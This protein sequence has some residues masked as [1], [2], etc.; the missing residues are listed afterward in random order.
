M[1]KIDG[2]KTLFNELISGLNLIESS[3]GAQI[4]MTGCATCLLLAA[5]CCIISA[6]LGQGEVE[7]ISLLNRDANLLNR[8][9]PFSCRRLR[10]VERFQY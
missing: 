6:Q 10:T 7:M 2:A 3:A 5:L 1:H 4:D 8:E 9:R